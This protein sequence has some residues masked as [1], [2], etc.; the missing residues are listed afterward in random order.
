MAGTQSLTVGTGTPAIAF[1]SAVPDFG[2]TADLWFTHDGYLFE[3]VTYPDRAQ[4]LQQIIDTIR[5]P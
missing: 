3:I 2:P 5:F 1:T 4:W